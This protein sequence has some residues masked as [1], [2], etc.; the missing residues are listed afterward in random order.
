MSQ[1]QYYEQDWNNHQYS[2]QSQWGYN[3]PESYCQLPYQYPASYT[4]SPEQ[5]LEESID[6]EKRMGALDELERWIQILEDSKFRQNFQVTDPYSI[7]LGEQANLEK[8]MKT[9]IQC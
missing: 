7:S 6:R 9:M 8:S 1:S 3:F 2:S 4:A 5:Q